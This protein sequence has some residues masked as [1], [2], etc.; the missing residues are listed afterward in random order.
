MHLNN[1]VWKEFCTF[2]TESRGEILGLESNLCFYIFINI[3]K[4]CYGYENKLYK[5]I[6]LPK[7]QSN[8][9]SLRSCYENKHYYL[10][11]S[12]IPHTYVF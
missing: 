5:K 6:I 11:T 7:T 2:A 12:H 9:T 1:N 10:R 3:W 4:I 8:Y